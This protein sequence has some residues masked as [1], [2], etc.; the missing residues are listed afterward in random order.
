[1]LTRTRELLAQQQTSF[2]PSSTDGVSVMEYSSVA[3]AQGDKKVYK[4]STSVGA[5]PEEVYALVTQ[6]DRW[7]DWKPATKTLEDISE[8]S[9]LLYTTLSL[10]GSS[11]P[12]DLVTVERM[13]TDPTG[14]IYHCATSVKSEVPLVQGRQRARIALQA[15]VIEPQDSGSRV[16]L[17]LQLGDKVLRQPFN[18][19][20]V[21]KQSVSKHVSHCITNLVAALEGAH[22]PPALHP[23]PVPSSPASSKAPIVTAAANPSVS[24]NPTR[25]R[26]RSFTPASFKRRKSEVRSSLG[27][28]GLK[29]FGSRNGSA[30]AFSY[31]TPASSTQSLSNP[32]VA[33]QPEAASVAPPAED[34][35]EA[36]ARPHMLEDAPPPSAL[37]G[38]HD[39]LA[40]ML[41]ETGSWNVAHS[42]E[43]HKIWTSLPATGEFLRIK[44]ETIVK[45]QSTESVLAAITSNVSRRSCPL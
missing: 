1:M 24:A 38:A 3:A 10:P 42:A 29:P 13:T 26:M 6:P 36:D 12:F 19:L 25:N 2:K 28:S 43:G 4:A 44:V 23:S 35:V 21:R 34:A 39:S 18:K 31:S 41:K 9:S 16:T 32:A 22:T 15:W 14:A 33:E 17:F 27:L 37:D 8:D 45:A 30:A 11:H 40:A 7:E 20:S 5:A